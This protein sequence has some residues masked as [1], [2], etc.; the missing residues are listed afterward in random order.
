[1]T[2]TRIIFTAIAALL[3]QGLLLAQNYNV[4]EDVASDPRKLCSME[5]PYRFEDFPSTAAPKGYKAF[6]LSHYGRHGSRYAWSKSTYTDLAAWLTQARDEDLLTEYG[7][8]FCARFLEFY[9]QAL[10]NTG[11][12]TALGCEQHRRIALKMCSDFPK[13]FRKGARVEM[14]SSTA[15]RCVMSMAAFSTALVSK[16]PTLEISMSNLHT[17]QAA[18]AQLQ[19]DKANKT[20][21]LSG[22]T[23]PSESTSSF[24]HRKLDYDG[25][26][27]RFFTSPDEAARKLKLS[28]TKFIKTIEILV[29]GYHNYESRDLFDDALTLE[30]RRQIW[31]VHNYSTSRSHCSSRYN[32]YPIMEDIIA[33]A[34]AAI[35]GNGVSA[36]LRFGHDHAFSPLTQLFNI[37]G[38]AHYCSRA[39]D[40]K[41]WFQNY[42]TPM[43]ANIQLVF[44]RS[45]K[46]GAPVLFKLLLNGREVSLPQ[47]SAVSG[48]YYKWDDFKSWSAAMIA[49][50]P[51]VD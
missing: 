45:S 3:C 15:S 18:I 35:A 5:G 34:D 20:K 17:E 41:Y 26:L 43:A 13:V 33:K 37:D 44:Y 30:Q 47:L 9:P 25:I 2:K 19:V 36:N 39:D 21:R 1:M 22:N 49:E 10:I 50:H 27:S 32:Q 6:Y 24:A 51:I 38:C 7:K 42:E 48:P 46:R 12:L 16:V 28:R 4:M 29:S 40:V 14:L 8:L 31:E 23:M 11:D